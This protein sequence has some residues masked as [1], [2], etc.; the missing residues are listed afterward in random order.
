VDG[1]VG[2]PS[3]KYSRRCVQPAADCWVRGKEWLR[4]IAGTELR[5][6]Q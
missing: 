4:R 1:V 2:E 3:G 6:R 5:A